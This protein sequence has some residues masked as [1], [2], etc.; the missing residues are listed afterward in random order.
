MGT[1]ESTLVTP[2][3]ARQVDV[4]RRMR[5]EGGSVRI[6]VCVTVE[7]SSTSFEEIEEALWGAKTQIR[8]CGQ[9]R[10]PTIP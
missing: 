9:P 7:V 1:F 4:A 2:L 6:T 3:A 5:P 10:S 8:P